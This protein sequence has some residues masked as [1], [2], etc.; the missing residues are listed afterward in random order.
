MK[1][2]LVIN[3]GSSSLKFAV[4]PQ[5]LLEDTAAIYRGQVEGIGE[6]AHIV[7]S[8]ALGERLLDADIDT[9]ASASLDAQHGASFSTLLSWLDSED[10]QLAGVGHRVL[11]GGDK[12]NAPVRLTA[13]IINEL[14]EFIPLGPLHQPHN[15]RP[16]RLLAAR[17]PALPQVAC[18][19]TAF[20]QTQRPLA[21]T[22]ALPRALTDSGIKRYG[23]HGLSYEYIARQLP[24]VLG[25][26]AHGGVVVAHLG[27]GAS[28]CAMRDLKSVA[29]SMGF[30]AAEGLMMGTR[31][32]SID[33]GVLLHLM[34]HLG[35]DAN[36]IANVIYRESGLLG[37]SG[38]SHDMRTLEASDSPHAR[39]AIDLFCYR[40]ARE[41][42]SLAVALGGIDAL[43]F[44]GGIGE[45]A[46]GV[47]AGI[48]KHLSWMGMVMDERANAEKRGLFRM[49]APGSRI[50]L[51]VVPTNEEWM[52]AHHTAALIR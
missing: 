11:H 23:F 14:A 43:V 16:T 9:P 49:D 7:I 52:I 48:V 13:E 32:G 6:R 19:D 18:F 28:M 39:E 50:A 47:R 4:F 24:R 1:N 25:A 33:P 36:K 5:P 51:A 17:F 20:H 41:V 34:Q 29:T 45:H 44:T 8:N 42:G 38:I 35:Y 21:T 27:N 3:A 22:Y 12:F 15:L 2:I 26:K 37:V 46:S 40:A 30:T 10:V 31:T